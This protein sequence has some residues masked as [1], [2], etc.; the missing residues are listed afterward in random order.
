MGTIFPWSTKFLETMFVL[1]D[2]LWGTKC[3]GIEC[4]WDQMRSSQYFLLPK[5]ETGF[6][7]FRVFSV[8][9]C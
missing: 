2:Q 8:K 6:E 4:V 7:H 5:N 1:R 3:L 9:S